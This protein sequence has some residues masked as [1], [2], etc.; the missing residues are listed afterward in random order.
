MLCSA[1]YISNNNLYL[2]PTDAFSVSDQD[3]VEKEKDLMKKF[4]IIFASLVALAVIAFFVIFNAAFHQGGVNQ[5]AV[6]KSLLTAFFSSRA[7][8]IDDHTY[9]SHGEGFE[10]T[11]RDQGYIKTDQLGSMH[12]YTKDGKRYTSTSEMYSRYFMLYTKPRES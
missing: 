9:L 2:L 8:M 5:Q 11:M 3:V 7:V 10:T 6:R 1:S 4:L 12:V